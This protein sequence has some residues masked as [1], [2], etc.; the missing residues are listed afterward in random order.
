MIS[1]DDPRHR[2][3]H[4]SIALPCPR[5]SRRGPDGNL[6][7]TNPGSQFDRDDQSGDPHLRRVRHAHRQCPAS[8]ISLR[9][10]MATLWFT[11]N[12]S[13]KIE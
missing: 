7:F 2:G 8:G 6:W 1:A 12:A 5:G 10:P 9:V 11:E 4:A 13:H 3:V